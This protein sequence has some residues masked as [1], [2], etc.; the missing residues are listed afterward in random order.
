MADSPQLTSLPGFP[1]SLGFNPSKRDIRNGLN[2]R[3]FDRWTVETRGSP[4]AVVIKLHNCTYNDSVCLQVK[5][6]HDTQQRG[7]CHL[8]ALCH[9]AKKLKRYA[10]VEYASNES[11]L[12]QGGDRL[13]CLAGRGN[14]PHGY[15]CGF[16]P[17]T[18]HSQC[19]DLRS[20]TPA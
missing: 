13:H 20:A 2:S 18:I 16:A 9:S 4:L 11:R 10:L 6:L 8:P 1:T 17:E 7:L 14:S 15:R 19:S 12:Y 3:M 5:T